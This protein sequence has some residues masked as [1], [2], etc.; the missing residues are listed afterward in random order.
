MPGLDDWIA[1][2]SDGTKVLVVLVVAVLLGLR[3]ASDPD[4]MAA[5]VTLTADT[6]LKGK[7]AA[8]RLGASWGLGHGTS[9]V[10]FGLPFVLFRALL[11]ELGQR[12][13]EV[14]VAL[15]VAGLAVRLLV[16]W[17]R[18]AFRADGGP[19]RAHRHGLR[20]RH[21]HDHT[22]RAQPRTLYQAFLIG[23]LHGAGGTAG[24][25]V[26]L[27]ASIH[28]RALATAALVL[29]AAFAAVSMALMTAG[30]G[31][32]LT[33]LRARNLFGLVAPTLGLASLV[34]GV[35]LGLGAL[36]LAPGPM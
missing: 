26:L 32:G 23:L 28:D 25:G 2:Y 5:V 13:I 24:L 10:A 35:W 21:C 15:V 31:A 17:R 36:A 16:R 6:K 8:A 14:A 22:H 18:G 12:V 4:H 30:L 3:H 1:G 9:L 33:R 7:R 20:L 27:L 11:P 29:F 19:A 34:F